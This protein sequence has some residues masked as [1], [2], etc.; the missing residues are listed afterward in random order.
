MSGYF[1]YFSRLI[2]GMPESST[3]VLV[4]STENT[5]QRLMWIWREQEIAMISLHRVSARLHLE[6][7][8]V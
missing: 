3:S 5:A 7:V 6:H 8:Q 2:D 4:E 1:D